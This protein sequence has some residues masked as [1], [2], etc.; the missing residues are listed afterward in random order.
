METIDFLD[1]VRSV[2]AAW[3][4]RRIGSTLS[5]EEDQ[6]ASDFS[7]TF[8]AMASRRSGSFTVDQATSASNTGT[9]KRVARTP[10]AAL[11]ASMSALY[12]G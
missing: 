4:T 3:D 2:P 7:A 1:P 6:A 10:G 9:P 8:L 12:P 11:R 5:R